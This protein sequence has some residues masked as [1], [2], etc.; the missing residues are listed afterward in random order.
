MGGALLFDLDGTLLQSDPLHVEV[1]REIFAEHRVTLTDA[2]YGAHIQ[3]RTNQAIFDHFLPGADWVALGDAKEARFRDRLGASVAPTPGL[4]ELLDRAR[5]A[6]LPCAVVTNAPRANA[7]AMLAA[8]GLTG[9]FPV[10]IAAGDT[11]RGKP[12]PGPYLA[13]LAGLG[14]VASQ[15]LAF[16]DSPSGIAAAVAAGI[17]TVG[18]PFGAAGSGAD[19]GPAPRW[20]SRISTIPRSSRCSR[21]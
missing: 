10:V 16:E 6:G 9:R 7:D 13:A 2:E 20:S 15:A 14:A 5:D 8:I 11:P 12:D 21:A 4:P 18:H 1:F 17:L 3:G 19:R